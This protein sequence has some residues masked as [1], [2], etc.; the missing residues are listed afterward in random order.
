MEPRERTCFFSKNGERSEK[1]KI[2]VAKSYV[3]ARLKN[4]DNKDPCLRSSR[5]PWTEPERKREREKNETFWIYCREGVLPPHGRSE[6][7]VQ[8][9]A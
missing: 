4:L 1:E 7:D 8:W 9:W 6:I 2:I 5:R 3:V